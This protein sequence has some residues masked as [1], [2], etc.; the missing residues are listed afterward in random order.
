MTSDYKHRATMTAD[1]DVLAIVRVREGGEL[2][3]SFE[4]ACNYRTHEYEA[5]DT[6]LRRAGDRLSVRAQST[7]TESY[8]VNRL[9]S[10]TS[11]DRQ[12]GL[13]QPSDIGIANGLLTGGG[14]PTPRNAA[15]LRTVIDHLKHGGYR[16]R[17]S[18]CEV[19]L[20]AAGREY[21]AAGETTY[22]TTTRGGTSCESSTTACIWS[23][24]DRRLRS[25]PRRTGARATSSPQPA[26]GRYRWTRHRPHSATSP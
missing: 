12:T 6:V 16:S 22:Q 3:E 5:Q 15:E 4:T 2:R 19:A 9:F 26:A 17:V 13:R 23:R 24:R 21:R 14:R 7:V 1:P 11:I 18:G 20:T 8:F 25:W 10:S